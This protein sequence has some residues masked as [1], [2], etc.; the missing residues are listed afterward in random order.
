MSILYNM[1]FVLLGYSIGSI[2]F[3]VILSTKQKNEDIRDSGS[4]NAG[5]TNGVRLYGKKF[6]ITIFFLD[7]LKAYIPLLTLGLLT[8]FVPWFK[9]NQIIPQ[10]IG[11]GVIIGH[12]F[13]AYHKF[14][15][16]KG[17]SCTVALILSMN[18]V[19]WIIAAV[20]FF[21]ITAWKKKVSLTVIIINTI[22]LI[23][24]FVPWMAYGY[25]FGFM[26]WTYATSDISSNWWIMGVLYSINF[27]LLMYAHH[28]NILRLLKGN[29]NS[30]TKKKQ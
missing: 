21:S 9:N 10:V 24:S 28:E 25:P 7:F 2:N 22:M 12:I 20:L 19:M 26:N 29:E 27:F 4:G 15:G 18:F 17:V 8:M 16:G 14:K 30:F 11:I 1:L 6:G 3:S 5:A 23:L 13:P